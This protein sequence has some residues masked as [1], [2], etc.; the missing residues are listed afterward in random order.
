[1][2]NKKS[3]GVWVWHIVA[4]SLLLLDQITKYWVEKMLVLGEAVPITEM[5][6]LVHRHNKGAAFSFL[7]NAGGWQRYFFI[8]LAIGIS[9]WLVF[10]IQRSTAR[11]ETLGYSF[12]LGGALGN[13]FDRLFRGAVVD[14]LDIYWK[15]HHWPAFN[16]A[17]IAIVCGAGVLLA[18]ITKE[19]R[20]P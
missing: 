4:V 12:I 20:T 2:N 16:V 1:M 3:G 6:N 19:V 11:T 14:F 13:L 7:A 9:C 17:D 18:S 10:A 8:S 5:F 15:S